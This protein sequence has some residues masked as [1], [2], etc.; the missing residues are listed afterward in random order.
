MKKKPSGTAA[1]CRSLARRVI[2]KVARASAARFSLVPL[3]NYLINGR[4]EKFFSDKMTNE[5]AQFGR[6]PVTAQP[7]EKLF[8]RASL[9]KKRSPR[10]SDHLGSIP[11]TQLP[12][13]THEMRNELER[14]DR[15]ARLASEKRNGRWSV[16]N[17][18]CFPEKGG[19]GSSKDV[20]EA[21]KVK[22]SR[23]GWKREQGDL[24]GKENRTEERTCKTGASDMMS[25]PRES[26]RVGK[27]MRYPK[28][29]D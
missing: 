19:Q 18:A 12:R 14:A 23:S 29:R 9:S 17:P 7:V 28:E 15:R 21:E 3:P 13:E 11:S 8:C 4:C 22:K 20:S 2:Q 1:R 6:C 27:G 10:C 16:N 24:L 25:A 5:I 26:D